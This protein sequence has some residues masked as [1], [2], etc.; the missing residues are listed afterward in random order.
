MT[1]YSLFMKKTTTESKPIYGNNTGTVVDGVIH[2][3]IVKAIEEDGGTLPEVLSDMFTLT[4]VPG[5]IWM[6]NWA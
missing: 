2:T 5:G 6:L 1:L 3:A 4:R